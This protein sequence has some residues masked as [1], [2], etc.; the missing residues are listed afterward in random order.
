[1]AMELDSGRASS[2]GHDSSGTNPDEKDY[3]T[4][5]V[6]RRR[7]DK[8]RRLAFPSERRIAVYDKTH[9]SRSS[10]DYLTATVP[11]TVEL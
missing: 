5:S 9:R 10:L 7:R 11:S 4:F 3:A 1:M 2:A 8:P 6:R